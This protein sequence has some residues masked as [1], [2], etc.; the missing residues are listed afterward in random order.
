[1][2]FRLATLLYLFAL[3]AAALAVMGS[4]VAMLLVVAMAITAWSLQAREK[5]PRRIAVQLVIA[6]LVVGLAQIPIETAREAA[7]TAQCRG[8]L[9]QLALACL[10]Y[11]S[12]QRTLPPAV[13]TLGTSGDTQSWRLLVLWYIVGSH[14]SDSLSTF[15]NV[16]EPWNSPKNQL[17]PNIEWYEC[18][19][20]AETGNTSYLAV[21]DPRTVWNN[22]PPRKLEEITD[23]HGQ[24]ILLIDVGHSDIDWKEP[25]DLSFDEAVKLLTA[26]VDPDKFTGHVEQATFLHKQHYFR[27]V[28][29]LDGSV[30]R[31]RSPLDRET[32]IAL[33]TANGGETIDP[34]RL[35]TLGQAELRYDRIY[36]LALLLVIAVLPAVPTVRRRV[37]PSRFDKESMAA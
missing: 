3:A 18:P 23:D 26:P 35:D 16:D 6:I 22:D 19:S 32:A 21:V 17:M 5:A 24:T 31:L 7:R 33:L 29:M 8:S 34:A 9:R 13:T 28:A 30:Q 2:T 25:R 14:P 36:G 1:M 4:G 27:L 20:H 11:E 37:L 10:N 15:Y 12:G